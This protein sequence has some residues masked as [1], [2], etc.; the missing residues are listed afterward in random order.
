LGSK[1]GN[2]E[3]YQD[4]CEKKYKHYVCQ[5][6]REGFPPKPTPSHPP[7]PDGCPGSEKDGWK[8][9]PDNPS[10]EFCYQIVSKR[11]EGASDSIKEV[12]WKSAREQCRTMGGDLLSIASKE[13]S[14]SVLKFISQTFPQDSSQQYWIGFSN[15]ASGWTWTDGTP[16][17]YTHWA[18][19]RPLEFSGHTAAVMSY[20]SSSNGTSNYW[21]NALSLED[22]EFICKITKGVEIPEPPQPPS[23]TP[24]EGCR[25]EH[26]ETGFNLDYGDW[27]KVLNSCYFI[28]KEKLDLYDAREKCTGISGFDL[29]SVHSKTENDAIFGAIMNLASTTNRY[30]IGLR[31][32]GGPDGGYSWT[33]GSPMDFTY[34]GVGQPNDQDGAQQCVLV[35]QRTNGYWEDVNCGLEEGYICAPQKA[36]PPVV[37]SKKHCETGWMEYEDNCFQFSDPEKPVNWTT[38]NKDCQTRG[39][40]LA[41]IHSQYQDAY[42]FAQ[43]ARVVGDVWIGFHDQTEYERWSWADN[44]VVSYTNWAPGEPNHGGGDSSGPDQS[45]EDCTVIQTQNDLW[46]DLSCST[47]RT[48]VCSKEKTEDNGS[49]DNSGCP[50]GFSK[51]VQSNG[52]A[53]CWLFDDKPKGY[54][55]AKADCVGRANG[56]EI[57]S[58]LEK[59]EAYFAFSLHK[60][61]DA[62]IGLEWDKVE[63]SYNWGDGWPVRYT[64]WGSG[65]P[66]DEKNQPRCVIQRENVDIGTFEWI[67]GDCALQK[68]SLCVV[69][70]HK[71]PMKPIDI[72]GECPYNSGNAK[73]Y[74]TKCIWEETKE[75][76]WLDADLEC[77][78]RA[79]KYGAHIPGFLMS[80]HNPHDVDFVLNE[81]KPGDA[82]IGLQTDRQ[83][84]WEWSDDTAVQFIN[85]RKGEPNGDEE[86]CVHMYSS[87]GTWNDA[88]CSRE[89]TYLC[90]API[91]KGYDENSD[92]IIA[93]PI[94]PNG[95]P[96][97]PNN[98]SSGGASTGIGG[99]VVGILFGVIVIMGFV[100]YGMYYV[101]K[102]KGVQ[103]GVTAGTVNALGSTIDNAGNSII[104]VGSN[105]KSGVMNVLYG[106]EDDGDEEL[107]VVNPN[108][109]M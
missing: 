3:W 58:I 56:A 54:Y 48:F 52:D 53:H 20:K 14:D 26:K 105:L 15:S 100:A 74:S 55:Q 101:G 27:Y 7:H 63:S 64:A 5:K 66:K 93:E 90:E 36:T 72:E 109:Q 37:I 98:D 46:N 44:S 8:A 95:P 45:T 62:W 21:E 79:K 39:G 29:A 99:E 86:H 84:G 75:K 96:D 50:E 106:G 89:K 38:A 57:A 61:N 87:D 24:D 35:S 94:Y 68:S 9:N 12:N 107:G 83:G 70:A 1:N 71:P 65:Y 40:F 104:E 41:S 88:R 102:N 82:W 60:N 25:S 92:G 2:G 32:K 43:S 103:L 16:T 18:W 33:D 47:E 77:S 10:S 73:K 76:Q 80:M 30:Y 17:L 59:A 49:N 67:E 31:E 28:S 42:V 34:W 108:S 13:E 6:D 19:G 91:I 23:M 51:F 85:W 69:R 11:I 81:V 78:K 22:R 4:D 97:R